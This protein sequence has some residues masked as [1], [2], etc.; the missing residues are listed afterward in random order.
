MKKSKKYKK[1]KKI[2]GVLLPVMLLVI[3]LLLYRQ[4]SY[5]IPYSG[6]VY[7][8]AGEHNLS[9]YLIYSVI[10]TESNFRE[11]ATSSKGAMGLMQITEETGMWAAEKAGVDIKSPEELYSPEK[12]IKIGSWYLA[13]LTDEMDGNLTNALCAYNAGLTNVKKW[14]SD[15]E[16]SNDGKNLIKIPFPETEKYVKKVYRYYNNYKGIYEK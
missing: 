11:D 3:G 4:V 9:P 5:K 16:C 13:Y 1:A 15:K 2:W 8:C 6:V 7:S 12:N 10:K 14:L